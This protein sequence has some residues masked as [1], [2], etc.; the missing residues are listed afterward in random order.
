MTTSARLKSAIRSSG[1]K[2]KAIADRAGVP[3]QTLHTFMSK[4]AAE[5]RASNLEKVAAAFAALTAEAQLPRKRNRGVRETGENY[6]GADQLVVAVPLRPEQ[7]RYL[8]EHGVDA[9]AVARAGAEKALKEAE[10][11]AWREANRDAIAA[12]N[13]WIAKHGTLAEQLG[14]I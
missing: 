2:L 14:L 12:Y 1:L 6:A 10:A 5:M 8:Q 9:E 13:A 11:Q 4:A 3:Q 7:A